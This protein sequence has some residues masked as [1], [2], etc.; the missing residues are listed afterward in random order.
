MPSRSQRTIRRPVSVRGTGY[1]SRRENRVEFLPAPAGSGVVFVRGDRDVPVRIAAGVENRVDAA[2]R[3]NLSVAGVQVQM[4]EHVL[5]ALAGLGVDC[6]QVRVSAEELPGLDGSALRFVE[7]LDEAG[8]EDL[9]APIDPLVVTETL[10]AGDD[11]AW[12]EVS[13]PRHSGLTVEYELDYGPGPIGR[14]RLALRVTPDVYRSDLAAARTFLAQDE[15]NR[16]VAAG[17]GVGVTTRDLVVF[18]PDGPIDNPLRWSDEC[19]RHKVLDL[20]GDLA[21]VGRPLHAHVRARRSG[22]QL[23]AVMAA[24]LVAASGRR[25]SA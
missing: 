20:V 23:N 8:F 25:A 21:L 4:V 19:V 5:S 16:L 7:A 6:C 18:G 11:E 3:T 12:I 17:L 9:G 14:Q 1:W 22:H 15:A 13:P 2:L 24:R 10:R